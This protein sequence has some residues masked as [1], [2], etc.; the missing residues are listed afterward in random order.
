MCQRVG[1]QQPNGFAFLFA[2]RVFLSAIVSP[3][4]DCQPAIQA[5]ASRK[6]C[7]HREVCV[8]FKLPWRSISSHLLQRSPWCD[9]FP[10]S[11]FV[12]W[13]LESWSS[14]PSILNFL[15]YLRGAQQCHTPTGTPVHG[16][17]LCPRVRV[18]PTLPAKPTKSWN[19]NASRR[20]SSLRTVTSP[21]MTLPFS[22][23][24]SHRSPLCGKG[25]GWVERTTFFFFPVH[26]VL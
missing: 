24:R 15:C 3:G 17:P 25:L 2:L 22:S 12:G 9:P 11:C 6:G 20:G 1:I 26:L 8:C 10:P 21:P 16:L 14:R 4:W 18:P 19:L 13:H 7:L 23:V 5:G